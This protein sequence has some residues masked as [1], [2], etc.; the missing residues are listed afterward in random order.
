MP[1]LYDKLEDAH[2]VQDGY[3]YRHVDLSLYSNH[4]LCIQSQ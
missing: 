4:S 2:D 1:E 3:L